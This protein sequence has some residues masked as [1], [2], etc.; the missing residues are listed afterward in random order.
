MTSVDTFGAPTLTDVAFNDDGSLKTTGKQNVKF[1]NK[2]RLA[3]RGRIKLDEEGAPVLDAEG[4]QIPIIDPRTGIPFKDAY[5]QIVEMVRI[6]TKGDT[7][8]VDDIAN[9]FHRKQFY[10]QWKYFREGRIPD[11]NPIEDF[12]LFQSPGVIMELHLIGIHTIQQCALMSDIEC[13]QLKD[14]SGYE[15]RDIAAQWVKINTPQGQSAKANRLET[16]N[17]KLRRENEEL[18]KGAGRSMIRSQEEIMMNEAPA[19]VEAPMQTMEIDPKDLARNVGRP[20][21]V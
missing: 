6:E 1:Y 4:K 14:Q 16:E 21:K 12:D 15:I 11:G 8:I 10:R 5:E 19:A 3:Y 20:R 7:N 13:G 2:T 17:A 18:R 9:D